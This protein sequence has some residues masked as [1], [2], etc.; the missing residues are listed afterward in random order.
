M[1]NLKRIKEW[2]IVRW[3]LEQARLVLPQ[4]VLENTGELPDH[5]LG[6]LTAYDE[7]LDYNELEL[8]LD[9]LE[10]LGEL[11]DCRGGFWRSLEKAAAL[12]GL[13]ERAASLHQ[14]FEDVLDSH[15]GDAT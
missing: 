15:G 14:K 3:H 4:D 6:T 10:G 9:Q 8:A 12:M 2:K 5:E 13:E 7:Y 1:A 11:N